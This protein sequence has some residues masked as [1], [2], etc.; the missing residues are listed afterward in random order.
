MKKPLP[1][2]DLKPIIVILVFSIVMTAVVLTL[3]AFLKAPAENQ[4]S[5]DNQLLE[6]RIQQHTAAG[7][8]ALSVQDWASAEKE[9]SEAL[10]L[11]KKA[12]RAENAQLFELEMILA[13][14]AF[15][16]NH[17]ARARLHLQQAAGHAHAMH[18][19]I[20]RFHR[21]LQEMPTGP[22]PVMPPQESR[23]DQ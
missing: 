8:R 18:E 15:H 11:I 2:S 9:Y 3:Y 23:A 13:E 16:Q 4:H 6:H 10:E 14:C 1:P 5:L 22:N 7:S 20:S 19:R 21:L 17:P 12:E